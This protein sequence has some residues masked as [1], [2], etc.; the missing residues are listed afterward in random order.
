MVRFRVRWVHYPEV[1]VLV[2]AARRDVRDLTPPGRPS[3]R[4]VPRLSVGQQRA[5]ARRKVV[6]KELVPLCA[7]YVF[8]IHHVVCA[9]R[10]KQAAVYRLLEKRQLLP[11]A[12]WHFHD[13]GLVGISKPRADQHLTTHRVPVG[14]KGVAILRVSPDVLHKRGRDLRHAIHYEIFPRSNCVFLREQTNASREK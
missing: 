5:L 10:V 8:R 4:S 6:T 3:Q 13:V 12:P 11:R 14:L 9:F 1:G 2:V 7:A